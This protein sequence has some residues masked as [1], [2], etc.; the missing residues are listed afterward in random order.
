[1][2]KFLSLQCL[3]LSIFNFF[4][5]PQLYPDFKPI[6]FAPYLVASFYKLSKE[7][8][9]VHA[10]ILGIFCDTASSYIFGVHAFLYV[11]TSA[12]LYKTHKIFLKEKWLSLPIITSIY[13]VIFVYLSYPTL[14]FFNYTM[15]W[16]LASLVS[17]AK[18]TVVVGFIYSIITYILPSM[19]TRSIL[20]ITTLLKKLLCY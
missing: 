8:V 12:I 1:M 2:D 6:F 19:I 10:L 4:L 3:Y 13:S 9:L 7:K 20:K 16:S 11:I 18:H 15:T 5:F 17:E 14:A